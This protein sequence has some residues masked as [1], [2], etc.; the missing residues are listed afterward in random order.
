[1][2]SASQALKGL[3]LILRFG[4]GNRS[5]DWGIEMIRAAMG[6][7]AGGYLDRPD[8]EPLGIMLAL[9]NSNYNKG[10]RNHRPG[11]SEH[12]H[13]PPKG[14]HGPSFGLELQVT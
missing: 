8:I 9:M 6:V 5:Q 13:A 1:M 12:R 4:L 10:S 7:E 3:C 14:W 11:F 2:A